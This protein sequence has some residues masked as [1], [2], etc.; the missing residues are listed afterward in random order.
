MSP[1]EHF[2]HKENRKSNK[3]FHLL[4]NIRNEN[5]GDYDLDGAGI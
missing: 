2:D 5:L 3:L 4:L 1:V